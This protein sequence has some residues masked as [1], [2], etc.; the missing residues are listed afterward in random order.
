M[1][2]A[3]WGSTVLTVVVGPL[4][5]LL[6]LRQWGTNHPWSRVDLY[7][8][9]FLILAVFIG[10]GE[11]I[12]FAQPAFRS[13]DVAYEAFGVSYDPLL[14]RLGTLLNAAVVFV[15]LDY[16]GMPGSRVREPQ[17]GRKSGRPG[18]TRGWDLIFRAIPRGA[19]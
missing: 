18:P 1:N 8:G 3:Y 14:V 2:K 15:I 9:S 6:C 11:T 12:S 5:F 16:A 19:Q 4:L 10:M 7:S 17:P 13:K